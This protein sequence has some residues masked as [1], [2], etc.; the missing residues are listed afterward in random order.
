MILKMKAQEELKF[1]VNLHP[2]HS[3]EHNKVNTA[4]LRVNMVL[5]RV[6]MALLKVSMEVNK[7]S[8]MVLLLKA[9]LG[10]THHN[11]EANK[12]AMV[13]DLGF[14][15]LHQVVLDDI[16]TQNVTGAPFE[17]TVSCLIDIFEVRLPCIYI[18][19]HSDF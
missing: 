6:S 11:K 3:P 19:I 14:L 16:K 13:E 8:N 10:D 17:N 7:G 4:L 9:N 12:E 1:R 5:L 18:N 15:L 2:K